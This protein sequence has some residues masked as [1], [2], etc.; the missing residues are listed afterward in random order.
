MK[1]AKHLPLFTALILA[2]GVSSAESADGTVEFFNESGGYG[3][4]TD[5][6]T[7]E[8]YIFE[9]ADISGSVREGDVVTFEVT[10]EDDRF[11][12]K[13]QAVA[14]VDAEGAAEDAAASDDEAVD[15]ET[16]DSGDQ[17]ADAEEAADEEAESDDGSDE[18]ADDE[19]E[20]D[21]GSDESADDGSE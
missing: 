1:D 6:E 4:V 13:A 2:A 9:A 16:D 3:Y 17:A 7:D 15:D 21:D 12:V 8:S 20:S 18:S 11:S 14:L 10:T 5:N 19:A